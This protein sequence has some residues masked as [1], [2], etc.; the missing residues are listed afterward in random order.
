[1]AEKMADISF[2]WHGVVFKQLQ[3]THGGPVFDG[4]GNCGFLKTDGTIIL[5]MYI[6]KYI[7]VIPYRLPN[8]VIVWVLSLMF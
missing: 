6:I 2:D 1:M 7:Y 8:Y 4:E 5:Y 3:A